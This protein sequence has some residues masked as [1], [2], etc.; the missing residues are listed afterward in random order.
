MN[1]L[2]V[3]S[4]IGSFSE[5][6]HSVGFNSVYQVEIEPTRQAVLTKHFP[7]AKRLGD[8]TK[9]NTNDI[10]ETIDIIC[11]GTPCQDLSIAGHGKGLAGTR[12]GLWYEYLRLARELRPRWLV[13]ENVPNALSSNNGRDFREI[14]MGLDEC[15]YHVAWRIL[16]AA[17]FGIPQRRRRIFLVASLRDGRA[18]QVLFESESVPGNSRT[19]PSSWKNTPQIAGTLSASASGTARTGNGNEADMLVNESDWFTPDNA[20]SKVQAATLFRSRQFGEYSLDHMAGT[21]CSG[22]ARLADSDL[23]LDEAAHTERMRGFG[24]Y[25]ADDKASTLKERDHK[26]STDLVV[27]LQQITSPQNRSNPSLQSPTLTK[28]SDVVVFTPSRYARREQSGIVPQVT[29][30]MATLTKQMSKLS[31]TSPHIEYRNVVRRLTPVECARLQGFPD[32]WLDGL[33]LSDTKKY[34][35]W[36]DTIALPC[37]KWVMQR[38]A[39]LEGRLQ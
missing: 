37:S 26:D 32:D 20:P 28:N 18:A 30:T 25:V 24:D 38:I 33:G 1:V 7:N 23:V 12:S 22:R 9:V 11:G 4:G 3:C 2:D 31:D 27:D 8:L 34:E 15:G 17:Y 19:R 6:S 29:D 10:T 21:L 35:M 13:W 39:S 16:D 14:L 36:G 5:A